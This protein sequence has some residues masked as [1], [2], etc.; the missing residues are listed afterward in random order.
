[1]KKFYYY[2]VSVFSLLL[3]M[4]SCTNDDESYVDFSE[5]SNKQSNS[6]IG[7]IRFECWLNRYAFAD[8]VQKQL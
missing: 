4:L 2:I 1:M 5:T 3:L 7:M 8:S 6:I